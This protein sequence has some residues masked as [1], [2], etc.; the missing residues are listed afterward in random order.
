MASPEPISAVVENAALDLFYRYP[1]LVYSAEE[2]E[3]LVPLVKKL[4]GPLQRERAF[5]GLC[6]PDAHRL[7]GAMV[8]AVCEGEPVD[9][10]TGLAQ[11]AREGL[12]DVRE[13]VDENAV[14]R[15]LDI[16]AGV[17]RAIRK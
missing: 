3:K 15:S 6:W 12:E 8:V 14:A 9:V 13:W 16:I 1:R 2:T 11:R 4:G 17:L 7:V 5:A 10:L